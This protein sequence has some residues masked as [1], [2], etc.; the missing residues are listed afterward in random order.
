[1]PNLK[2]A[3]KRLRQN[4][5]RRHENMGVR[6]RV[7]TARRNFLESLEGGSAEDQKAAYAAYCSVLDRAAKR[8]V[9]KKNN[10]IRN[11]R[12]AAARMA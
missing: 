1:M 6:S 7:R 5:T 4:E 12:R 9:L 8:G 3:K 10:A 11:K 2:S